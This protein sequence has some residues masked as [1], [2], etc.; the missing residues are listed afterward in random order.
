MVRES[1]VRK[2]GTKR[3]REIVSEVEWGQEKERESE[4][5]REEESEGVKE[6]DRRKRDPMDV[7]K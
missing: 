6:A 4:E 1:R 7:Q 2:K 5:R 3:E